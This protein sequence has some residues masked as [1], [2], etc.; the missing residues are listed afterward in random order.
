MF[1]IS[2]DTLPLRD[3][4]DFWSRE[5]RPPATFNELLRCLESAWWRG[6]FIGEGALSRLK[7]LQHLFQSQ[8]DLGIVFVVGDESEAPEAKQLPDGAVEIDIRP[9]IRVPSADADT[10]IETNCVLAYED[11]AATSFLTNHPTMRPVLFGFQL[12]RREFMEWLSRR[13]SARPTF[14]GAIDAN[15][16]HPTRRIPNNGLTE[17]TRRRGRR[18]EKLLK[19][20]EEMRSDIRQRRRTV[21]D[22]NDML[23]K[24]LAEE[25]SVSRDTARKARRNVLSEIHSQQKP[26]N[27]K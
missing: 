2:D 27:D 26:T 9:R 1:P 17:N 19:V 3:I 21:R 4:A 24:E 25:Y 22:L 23:E 5:I 13:G 12:S 6:E 20:M 18:P 10:W 15:A 16:Y 14:W 11:L 7:L 8:F